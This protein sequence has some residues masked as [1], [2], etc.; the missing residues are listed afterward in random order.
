MVQK[1]WHQI[2]SHS[3]PCSLPFNIKL[4]YVLGIENIENIASPSLLNT[5]PYSKIRDKNQTF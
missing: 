1:S 3:H 4:L 5:S 2:N